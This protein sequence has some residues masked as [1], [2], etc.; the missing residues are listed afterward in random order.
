MLKE[1][2]NTLLLVNAFERKNENVPSRNLKNYYISYNLF[3]LSQGLIGVFLSLFFFVNGGYLAVLEFQAANYILIGLSFA[4]SGYVLQDYHPKQVYAIAEISIVVLLT[5][6]L[7]LVGYLSNVILFGILF[8]AVS[9]FFWAGNNILM[10]AIP[11]KSERM[12]FVTLNSI[13]GG[14]IALAAPTMGGILIQLS[15]FT[16]NLRFALDFLAASLFLLVSSSYILRTSNMAGKKPRFS[17]IETLIQ[18]GKDY[19]HFKLYFFTSQF[20]FTAFSII[21]PIYVFE[22][23][24]SFVIAGIFVSYTTFLSIATNFILRKG[25]RASSRLIEAAIIGIILS[26][27]LLLPGV[28]AS[29]ANVFVFGGIFTVLSTPLENAALVEFM[30]HLDGKSMQKVVAL[31]I[32]REYY[33]MAG[34]AVVIGVLFLVLDTILKNPLNILIVFPVLALYSLSYYKIIKKKSLV[35]ALFLTM[36]GWKW[37]LLTTLYKLR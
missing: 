3:Q 29:P 12:K 24:S 33:L 14:I 32:N 15:N 22:I 31:W 13:I 16:G 36:R 20:F 9:G 25:F 35:P 37:N 11:Q 26:S 28:I 23:T 2:I 34:R 4:L 21:M 8:G 5:S 7:F 19:F 27:L 1:T 17:I 10:Y 18:K 30:R 6:M